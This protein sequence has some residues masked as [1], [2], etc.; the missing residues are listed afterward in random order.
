MKLPPD[1]DRQYACERRI[2][3]L[4]SRSAPSLLIAP[5]R[6]SVGKHP[7]SRST[8]SSAAQSPR[9]HQ[10]RATSWHSAVA[11]GLYERIR[12]ENSRLGSNR[13]LANRAGSGAAQDNVGPLIGLAHPIDKCHHSVCLLRIVP[14]FLIALQCPRQIAA[15]SLVEFLRSLQGRRNQVRQ[16]AV[17]C[18]GTKTST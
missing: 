11:D 10:R 13:K 9:P 2:S 14:Q 8:S 12:H 16:N 4:C 6:P 3:P 18:L 17:Q 5:D 15:S 1:R 7:L